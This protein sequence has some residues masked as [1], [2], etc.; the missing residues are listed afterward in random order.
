MARDLLDALGLFALPFVAYSLVLAF[1]SRYPFLAESWSRGSLAALT[2]AGL[3]LVALGMVLL[4]A[5]AD[6]GHGTL[7]PAHIEGGRLVPEQLR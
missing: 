5:T 4:A 2:V 1:R 7:V 3:A 6:R